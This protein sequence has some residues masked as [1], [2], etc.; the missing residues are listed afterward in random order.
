MATSHPQRIDSRY[1]GHAPCQDLS[2]FYL[3][4]DFPFPFSNKFIHRHKPGFRQPVIITLLR[5]LNKERY[6]FTGRR[7]KIFVGFSVKVQGVKHPNS[8]FLHAQCWIFRQP[9]EMFRRKIVQVSF[10]L[11]CHGICKNKTKRLYYA[12]VW[13]LLFRRYTAIIAKSK[14]LWL[15]VEPGRIHSMWKTARLQRS[16]SQPV[17]F[18]L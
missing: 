15:A 6:N 5:F 10:L 2:F 9:D 4:N 1:F 13:S 3:K 17:S 14:A 8:P 16:H 18:L 11:S 12:A 7:S